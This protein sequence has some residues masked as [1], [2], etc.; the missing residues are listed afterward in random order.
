MMANTLGRIVNLKRFEIH[1]GDGLRTTLFVKGCPL[2][3]KWCHNPES[4]A[5]KSELGY[6]E[7][8]CIS[9]GRCAEIC[10]YGAHVM[11]GGV[12]RFDRE[13][14]RACGKCASECLADALI[15]YGERVTVEDILPKLLSDRE[16]YENSG[17]G[18]TISGG[19]PLMQSEFCGELLKR[20]KAEGINTAV[21]TCLFATREQLDRVLPYTDTFLVDVKAIDS[22]LHKALTGQ[23][24]ECILD[25]IRYLDRMGKLMEVRIP[26]VPKQNSG[27]IEK[28]AD[29]LATLHALK[30]VRVLPYHSLS[31]M[32]YASIEMPYDLD[33]ESA[34]L[35]EKAEIE[36]AKDILRAKGLKVLE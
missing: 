4:I 32:K 36:R 2:H 7:N 25:N 28:I 31:S 18:V 11:E 1:D 27:E 34:P 26:Y 35:P 20:L 8:K 22:D 15:F 21:D 10:P 16:F 13:K 17:G 12:H 29:F 19:E 14:C 6:Y 5:P 9:C 3:C 33:A 24:N 30:G 23:P